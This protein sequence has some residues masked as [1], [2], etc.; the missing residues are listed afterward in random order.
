MLLL[1]AVVFIFHSRDAYIP[2]FDTYVHVVCLCFNFILLFYTYLLKSSV[3]P[4][5]PV[6]IWKIFKRCFSQNVFYL[7]FL[8]MT[9]SLVTYE[10]CF[11]SSFGDPI[12]YSLATFT[13]L[14]HA[15]YCA[16]V[17]NFF[18]CFCAYQKQLER[19]CCSLHARSSLLLFLNLRNKYR[20]VSVA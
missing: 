13:Y 15:S 7:T 11:F 17:R 6:L 14:C 20:Y 4:E 3:K 8:A 10:C 1:I 9:E 19:Q 5:I 12:G 2:V 18:S 16:R